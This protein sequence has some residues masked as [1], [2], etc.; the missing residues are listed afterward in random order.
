MVLP[1]FPAHKPLRKWT[2]VIL[3]DLVNNWVAA[4]IAMTVAALS[5]WRT[6]SIFHLY[7]CTNLASTIPIFSPIAAG[8]IDR[9]SNRSRSMLQA[10]YFVFYGILRLAMSTH[11]LHRFRFWENTS[12]QCF[13][14][15]RFRSAMIEILKIETRTVLIVLVACYVASD[16]LLVALILIM[17]MR[18][19]RVVQERTL[20]VLKDV[21]PAL[22]YAAII[23]AVSGFSFLGLFIVNASWT[24]IIV[25]SNQRHVLGDE[26][27][28]TFG[29]VGALV[30][31]A[32]SFY[33]IVNSFLRK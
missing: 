9:R 8:V 16:L 6:I 28:F 23:R 33:A 26:Y 15:L 25:Y 21:L 18:L 19:M 17:Q 30:A 13:T 32:G 12:G 22:P 31:L 29:Q 24:V 27:V 14:I 10:A 5:Q 4:G 20:E 3:L 7:I 11:L 1:F 2:G